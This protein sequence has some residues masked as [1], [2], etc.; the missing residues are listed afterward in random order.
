MGYYTKIKLVIDMK[1]DEES[2]KE[3]V[4]REAPDDDKSI[5][6]ADEKEK[7]NNESIKK[8]RCEPCMHCGVH[9]IFLKEEK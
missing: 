7:E 8:E 6:I 9:C 1:M 5:R 4:N 2:T 3:Q